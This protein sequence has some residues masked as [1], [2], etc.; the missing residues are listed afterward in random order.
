MALSLVL[1]ASLGVAADLPAESTR[2]VVGKDSIHVL[3]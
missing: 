3:R 2:V 1:V